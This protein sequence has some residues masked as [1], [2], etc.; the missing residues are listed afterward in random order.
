MNQENLRAV[1]SSPFFAIYKEAFSEAHQAG[2]EYRKKFGEP[3]YCGFAW[4]VINDG[5]SPFVNWC[6]KANIGHK[7]YGKGWQIWNPADDMTQSMDIKECEARA[8]ANALMKHG[9]E[10]YVGSRPD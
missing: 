1:M 6:R 3:M 10:C 5:R 4:V 9:I 2:V 8:F 7:N